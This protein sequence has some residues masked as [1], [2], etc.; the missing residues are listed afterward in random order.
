[1]INLTWNSGILG[2]NNFA[3]ILEMWRRKTGIALEK[4]MLIKIKQS[5]GV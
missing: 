5:N 1:M 3:Q 2:E 4:W